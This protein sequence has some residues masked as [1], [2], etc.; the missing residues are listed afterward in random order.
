ML[1]GLPLLY[2]GCGGDSLTLP[3]E[4]EPAQITIQAG[5]GESG[6][7]G[8]QLSDSLVALVTDTQNRPVPGA[9]VQFVLTDD[10]GGG[11]V[12]PASAQTGADGTAKAKITLGSQAGQMQGQAQVPVPSGA[13]PIQ[14]S[15]TAMVLSGDANGIAMVSGDGQSG[16]VGDTLAAPLTVKVTDAS[17]NPI[18]GVTV[19][20]SPEGQGSVSETTTITD[21]DGQ[22]SVLRILGPNAGQQT[23]TA[24]AEGLVGS[25]V[26]FTSTAT[27]GNASRIEIVSGDNQEAPAGTQLH[28]DLVVRVLDQD[29][30]PVPNRAVSWV[31]GTG[32]GTPS[33][34]TSQTDGDGKASTKWTLG[35]TA[36]PNTLNAVVSGIGSVTFH[37]NGTGTG[38]PSNL[39]ITTQP[40][41]SVGIGETLNPAPVVQV[42]DAAGHDLAVSGVEVTAALTGG[43]S[44]QLE[45]TRTV[46]TDGNGRAQFGDLRITGGT[47]SY[48]LLFAAEGF[49]SATSNKID[50]NKASTTTTISQ[51]AATSD[52]GQPVTFTVSVTSTSPGSPSGSIEVKASDGEKCTVAAPSGSC[53]IIFTGTGDRTVTATYS[54]DAAFATSSATVTHHVNEP[55][56]PPNNPPVAGNDQYSTP[57]GQPLVVP[58]PGVLAND[59]DPDGNPITAHLVDQATVGLVI[60]NDDGSFTYFPGAATAGSQDTFTYDV[61]DGS[62]TARATVTIS[63]Q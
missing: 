38:S 56:P 50:V 20:W 4:G 19:T 18:S 33:P 42:R 29:G 31:V 41:G 49:R 7:G 6:R 53:Q 52:P 54:G 11:T 40:P 36:G 28:D 63:I 44:G 9:T 5:S 45:G 13:A 60:L 25:P 46:A 59:S 47:G 15:F 12:T 22:T 23:T 61:S 55:T 8:T 48:R 62:L 2:A 58:T 32:G 10:R 16:P 26:T 21:D 57:A 35:G 1:A 30:N 34:E 39:A 24:T 43:G 51:D 27:A 17:G 37:A 14:A 3:S